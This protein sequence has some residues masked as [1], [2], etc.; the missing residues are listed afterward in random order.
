M[1]K[2]STLFDRHLQPEVVVDVPEEDPLMV[3]A[4]DDIVL[5]VVPSFV[6][7]VSNDSNSSS[8]Q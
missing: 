8:L 3:V 1:A 2:M 5:L 4:R 6:A 7:S